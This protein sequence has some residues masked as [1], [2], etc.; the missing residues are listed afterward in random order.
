MENF[1]EEMTFRRGLKE[2]TGH[3]AMEGCD[4]EGAIMLTAMF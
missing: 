1:V 2:W 4:M 3:G